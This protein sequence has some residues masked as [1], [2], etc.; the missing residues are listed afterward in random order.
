MQIEKVFLKGFRNY[1]EREFVFKD[2]INIILGKNGIGK[3]NLIE[4]IMFLS[5]GRSIKTLHLNEI[6]NFNSNKAEIHAV[7]RDDLGRINKIDVLIE[8][9]QK[10]RITVNKKLLLR[11]SDLFTNFLAVF[12]DQKEIDIIEG[13]PSIRR[14]H[15]DLILSRIRKEYLFNLRKYNEILNNK[16][17]LL[18]KEQI[19]YILY[20]AYTEEQKKVNNY[21]VK[22][23]TIMLK[24]IENSVNN[25]IKEYFRELGEM[26]LIYKNSFLKETE[27]V[28]RE[29]SFKRQCLYGI[30]RDDWYI[31]IKNK[32]AKKY[33]STGEKRLISLLIKAV[34][35]KILFKETGLKPII[36]LDDAFMGMDKK[37]Q[38]IVHGIIEQ[39]KENQIFI[40]STDKE[41]IP[42]FLDYSLLEL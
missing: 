35:I 21:I 25:E 5:M 30:H 15:L 31:S 34:E 37:R 10:K 42:C 40:T 33:L 18:Q 26:D 11:T 17:R 12:I 2:K 3:S 32:E 29:E 19:N 28:T 27:E 7:L 1:L 20:E 38:A 13:S 6:I 4:S 16:R 36:V 9:S 39:N 22:H 41:N 8:N 14:N 24:D 23:R